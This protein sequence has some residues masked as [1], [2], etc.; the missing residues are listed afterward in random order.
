M[1]STPVLETFQSSGSGAAAAGGALFEV[2]DV[3]EAVVR[4]AEGEFVVFEPAAEDVATGFCAVGGLSAL[5]DEH[6][7]STVAVATA[8]TRKTPVMTVLFAPLPMAHH[9]RCSPRVNGK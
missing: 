9:S 5:D 3:D 2:D 6:P 8:A 7:D 4:G 1:T